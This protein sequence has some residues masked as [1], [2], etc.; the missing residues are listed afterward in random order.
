MGNNPSTV[1]Q[2]ILIVGVI[3]TSSWVFVL[4]LKNEKADQFRINF[5]DV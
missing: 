4:V 3:F 1:I 2:P 5:M